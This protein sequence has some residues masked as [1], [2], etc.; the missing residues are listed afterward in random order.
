MA[1]PPEAL[2]AWKNFQQKELHNDLLMAYGFGDGGGGPTR[3]M[4]E[5]IDVM[6]DFPGL[7]R[8]RGVERMARRVEGRTRCSPPQPQSKPAWFIAEMSNLT[9]PATRDMMTTV[10]VVI[11]RG[12]GS[13]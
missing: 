8:L 5:N 3:E 1:N 7:P 4:L 10:P 11:M 12:R 9:P 6:A 2:G 13:V